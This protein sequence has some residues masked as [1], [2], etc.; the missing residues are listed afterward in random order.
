MKVTGKSAYIA[1]ISLL[2]AISVLLMFVETPLPL[3]PPFLKLDVSEI[4]A[5]LA[6][7]SMGPLAAVYVCLVK[8]ALHLPYS[9]TAGVGELANFLVGAA[10]VVPAGIVY[11]KNKTQRF[12]LFGLLA[13]GL[14]M[15]AAAAVLNYWV[16][17]PLYLKV[18]GIPQTKIIAWGHSA[19]ARIIDLPTFIAFGIVP[20]NIIKSILLSFAALIVYKRVSPVLHR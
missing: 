16:L 12:A 18:L 14:S 9:Q 6:A 15:T 2:A 13:G 8:N 19:N 3:F 17:I 1:K 11:A 20:F 4:P 7:F 10:F 5:L